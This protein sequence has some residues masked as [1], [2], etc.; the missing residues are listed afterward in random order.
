MKK[1]L[2]GFGVA[3]VLGC[4]VVGG[5]A[6]SYWDIDSIGQSLDA[7]SASYSSTFNIGAGDG[8]FGDQAGYDATSEQI[9][10]ATASFV[11]LSL[12]DNSRQSVSIDLGT[13]PFVSSGSVPVLFSVFNGAVSGQ[14]LQDLSDT[15][16]ITYNIRWENGAAFEAESAGLYA[17]SRPKDR[18]NVPDGGGTLGLL[19]LGLI[20]VRWMSRRVRA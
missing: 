19:G 13:T 5:R 4:G 10:S 7:G 12:N 9:V 1:L 2:M 18:D 20:G 6:N 11:F 15:G 17:E 3:G 8:D 14:I 16:V